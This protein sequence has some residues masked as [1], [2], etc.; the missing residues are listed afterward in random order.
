MRFLF[1]LLVC[2]GHLQASEFKTF[3]RNH[4]YEDLNLVP[5]TISQIQLAYSGPP[6]NNYETENWQTV[7]HVLPHKEL[8]LDCYYAR[9][10]VGHFF[11]MM[12]HLKTLAKEDEFMPGS[13]SLWTFKN[14]ITKTESLL[15]SNQIA[16]VVSKR[17][18]SNQKDAHAL[19]C[20]IV[21]LPGTSFNF[22]LKIAFSWEKNMLMKKTINYVPFL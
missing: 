10:R 7:R 5:Q 1:V 2:V 19:Y 11:A 8:W 6:L 13:D 4:G 21:T 3:S 15:K 18:I 20:E 14:P 9:G 17:H 12:P 16:L 22:C